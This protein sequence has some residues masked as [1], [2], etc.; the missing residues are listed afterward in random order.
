MLSPVYQPRPHHSSPSPACR[1]VP[2]KRQSF[3]SSRTTPASRSANG[4]SEGH[5]RTL[6]CSRDA[7]TE[8]LNGQII[9][10]S[11]GVEHIDEQPYGQFPDLI[12]Y[13]SFLRCLLT[14]KRRQRWPWRS[15][16]STHRLRGWKSE[17]SVD[18]RARSPLVGSRHESPDV[19][20]T[21]YRGR[22]EGVPNITA[23]N[24]APVWTDMD[25][26]ARK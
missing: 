6:F 21:R 1:S 4:S 15:M 9:R 7:S 25:T 26:T 5:D 2:T 19:C 22:E 18:T 12:G 20:G 3:P 10:F 13:R 8:S 24:S 17:S 16:V 14:F 23:S 11:P